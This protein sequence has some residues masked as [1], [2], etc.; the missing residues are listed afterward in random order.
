MLG[1][2]SSPPSVAEES[3]VRDDD[4]LA[5]PATN[6]LERMESEMMQPKPQIIVAVG[7]DRVAKLILKQ[8]ESIGY[9]TQRTVTMIDTLQRTLEIRPDGIIVDW[10][11][12]RN[13]DYPNLH[14]LHEV[15]TAAV[16][17]LIPRHENLNWW[18]LGAS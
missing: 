6:P 3:T 1:R 4:Q 10:A 14:S 17:L 9:S 18:T 7:G 5:R 8:L 13:S 16:L 15:T 11:L 2:S 12:L